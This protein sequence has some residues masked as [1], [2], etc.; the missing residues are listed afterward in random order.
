[1]TICHN[2]LQKMY[3]Q[4]ENLIMFTIRQIPSKYSKK[5]FIKFFFLNLFR[6]KFTKL[7]A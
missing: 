1:M 3:S 6:N 2:I 5:F 4:F 7:N